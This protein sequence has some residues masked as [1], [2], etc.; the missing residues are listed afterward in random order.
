LTV[1]LLDRTWPADAA[2]DSIAAIGVAKATCGCLA[3]VGMSAR[4]VV[5]FSIEVAEEFVPAKIFG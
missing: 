5:A 1:V 4:P 3:L 2:F